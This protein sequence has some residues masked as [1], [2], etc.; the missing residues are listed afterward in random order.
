MQALYDLQVLQIISH[1]F[2]HSFFLN[3]YGWHVLDYGDKYGHSGE[4][5]DIIIQYYIF[6]YYLYLKYFLLM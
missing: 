3:I 5:K 6:Q 2:I 1:S 4:G